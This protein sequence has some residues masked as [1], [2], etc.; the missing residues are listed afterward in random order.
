MARL[1]LHQFPGFGAVR[2]HHQIPDP[3]FRVAEAGECAEILLIGEPHCGTLNGLCLLKVRLPAGGFGPVELNLLVSAIAE[4]LV[5][6]LTAAAEG[7]LRLRRVFLSLPVIE[8]F[9]LGVS[10]DPL[11]TQRQPA[12]DKIGTIFGDFDLRI[13]VFALFHG[14]LRLR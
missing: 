14:C 2:L 9:A 1:V 10:D 3:A 4:G 12:A 11:F 6:R 7:I 8:G 13:R 5:R